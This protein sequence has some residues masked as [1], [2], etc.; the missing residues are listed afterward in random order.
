MRKPSA[1]KIKGSLVVD[2]I[3]VVRFRGSRYGAG[4]AVFNIEQ[5]DE[6]SLKVGLFLV[7]DGR[8]ESNLRL[9]IDSLKSSGA[10]V[11][12]VSK[13]AET[14]KVVDYRV[15]L[16]GVEDVAKLERLISDVNAV[17][18]SRDRSGRI[19]FWG[20]AIEVFKGVGY[21]RDIADLYNVYE[22]SGDLWVAHTRQPTNSPGY[23]PYWS[24]P[25]AAR[26]IAIV[27]NGDISSFGSNMNFLHYYSNVKSFVGTDSECVAF[28]VNHLLNYERLDVVTISRILVGS[29]SLDPRVRLRY[30]GAVLDGPF[31]IAIGVYCD[32]DLY[33]IAIVDRQKLRPIVV[34]EDDYYYYV[35]SEECQIRC[36]SPDAKVWTLE[37][38][39]YFVASYRK[40]IIKYGRSSID[41]ETF[42][43]QTNLRTR[44]YFR[45]QPVP[46]QD[47]VI[48]AYGLDYRQLNEL[49]LQKLL[50]GHST[51][52][53][54]NVYGQRYIGLNLMRHGVRNV[55]LEI[56]GVPGNCLGNLNEDIEFV[57]YGNAEDD[58][59]D[60]MHSGR[61]VIHGDVRDVVGQAL[62]GGYIFVRGNAGNR[63]GILMRE[64]REKRPYLIIGGR[65]DDYLAEYM[66]GG[67]IMVLGIDSYLNN[68]SVELTG[69]Y[70]GS[71]MVGGRVYVRG[72]L[73]PHKVG[74]RPPRLEFTQSISA[75]IEEGDIPEDLVSDLEFGDIEALEERLERGGYKYAL[76]LA[77][78]LYEST[79]IIRT[80]REYRELSDEEVRELRPVLLE[81]AKYFGFD[82]NLVDDLLGQKYTVVFR[83]SRR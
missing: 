24:H 34:G 4:Y 39:G 77:K 32:D 40:G 44:G 54:Y 7:K 3:D 30:R 66:A 14:D 10:S 60:T 23:Y 70:V 67:V 78:I 2:A 80:A 41:L 8:E 1:P 20:R 33:L 42:F 62:Q 74:L 36:I 27:H 5:R 61:I 83:Y 37:P 31:A 65:V 13:I 55:R 73:A 76:G 49:I 22:H 17:L 38:G 56:Y 47:N 15:T 43:E 50:E 68:I 52:K 46:K 57:V 71:G 59:G 18:W 63:V 25:F 53:I 58:V 6:L 26:D 11:S 75:L 72:R 64:Y 28:I 29:P 45:R 12:E 21:P 81:Y 48:D 19:Y 51:L 69:K 82:E 9:V 35:A 79:H 16:S